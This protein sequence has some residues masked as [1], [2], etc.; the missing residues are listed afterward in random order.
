[1]GIIRPQRRIPSGHIF[2]SSRRAFKNR[3][4]IDKSLSGN[5]SSAHSK[6]VQDD[7]CGLS[8]VREDSNVAGKE[9]DTV[10]TNSHY[11]SQSLKIPSALEIS[12]FDSK[13]KSMDWSLAVLISKERMSCQVIWMFKYRFTDKT[14]VQDNMTKVTPEHFSP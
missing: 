4:T 2:Q 1:M 7:G 5:L 3:S 14:W 10:N 12:K 9:M 11:S 8:P 6:Y 13:Q